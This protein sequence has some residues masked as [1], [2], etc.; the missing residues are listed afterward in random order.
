MNRNIKR[1]KSL[2][3]WNK[4]KKLVYLMIA[5][6]VIIIA[7]IIGLTKA[8]GGKSDKQKESTTPE[9]TTESMSQQETT[10]Q[11][12]ET[13]TEEPTTEEP[14]TLATEIVKTPAKEDFSNEAFFDDAVFVGDVFVSGM[15]I[16][17]YLKSSRLVYNE[18]WTTGKASNSVS[19]ISATNANKVFLEIGLNDLNTG[20]SGEKVF[21]SYQELVN[22]IKAGLPNA[23]I[24][25]ISVFPVTTGFEA[26]ENTGVTNTEISKL[27]ELLSTMEGVTYLNVSASLSNSDGSLMDD[28]SSSG[29][30]IKSTY[31]GFILNLI[32]EM[33]Q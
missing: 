5:V 4:Y 6:L 2:R 19:T 15:D 24:Y 11:E 14:T 26:K 7:I 21:E 30:N 33:C 12:P 20:K 10:T 29:Y 23:T 18:G 16:Y 13:T 1:S 9:T 22:D 27:N 28:L 3:T 8:I 32:A 25:V 17:G 31:Y